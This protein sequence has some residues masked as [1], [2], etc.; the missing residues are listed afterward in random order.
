MSGLRECPWCHNQISAIVPACPKCFR[1]LPELTSGERL[2]L[3]VKSYV[4]QGQDIYR[5]YQR[6][7]PIM[8]AQGYRA[9]TQQVI[10]GHRGGCLMLLGVLTF[11]ILLLFV[12]PSDTLM[13]TYRLQ[14]TPT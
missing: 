9:E 10:P 6:D 1:S 13:V 2:P 5:Q 8:E 12:R 3:L 4:G 7:L 14:P 11:G